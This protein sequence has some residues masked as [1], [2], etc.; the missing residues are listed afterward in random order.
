MKHKNPP[1][2][3]ASNIRYEKVV[4]EIHKFYHYEISIAE[5]SDATQNLIGWMQTLLEIKRNKRDDQRYEPS[6]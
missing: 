6:D 3:T 5:A 4:E 1:Q 2:K